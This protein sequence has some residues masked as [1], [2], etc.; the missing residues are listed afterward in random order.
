MSDLHNE[1]R[2]DATADEPAEKL[3]VD[4]APDFDPDEARRML[5][6]T[7]LQFK[8]AMARL[9]GASRSQ[10]AKVAGYAG[11]E[12]SSQLRQA[13]SEAA[14]SEKVIAFLKWAE[15]SGAGVPDEP[16]DATELRKIMS[17]HARGDD[18]NASIRACEVLHKLD[19]A[20]AE[21]RAAREAAMAPS[22]VLNMI[23]AILPDMAI[24]L[25]SKFG[26]AWTPPLDPRATAGAKSV[27]PSIFEILDRNAAVPNAGTTRGNGAAHAE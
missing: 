2:D 9:K 4:A 14:R 26:I 6:L 23:A 5:G 15:T 7:P 3:S 21:T 11:E 24:A 22:D 8:F 1:D 27:P 13:G 25:A 19:L 17:R 20:D 18:K 10:A 12:G 16:V